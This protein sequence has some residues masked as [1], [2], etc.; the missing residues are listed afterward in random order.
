MIDNKVCENC[1]N[2]SLSWVACNGMDIRESQYPPMIECSIPE[3][4]YLMYPYD[5]CE[6]FKIRDKDD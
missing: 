1:A 6:D 2:G 5:D 4:K 3:N